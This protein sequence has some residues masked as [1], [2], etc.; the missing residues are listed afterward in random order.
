[1]SSINAVAYAGERLRSVSASAV[2][3]A[4]SEVSGQDISD[5][6]HSWI[7]QTGY[8]VVSVQTAGPHKVKVTQHRF[9]Q[10]GN[11]SVTEDDLW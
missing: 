2:W 10:S 6:A 11:V 8:P 7:Y 4:I 5:I 9:L 1:M 3:K